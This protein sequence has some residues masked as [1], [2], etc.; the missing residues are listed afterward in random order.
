MFDANIFTAQ[1]GTHFRQD[2]AAAGRSAAHSAALRLYAGTRLHSR[3]AALFGRSQRLPDLAS[4]TR[5]S[6]L[7]GQH[8]AG[9]QTVRIDQI[10]GSE[11]R[12]QDFDAEF[13]PL[14]EHT[15]QR[16]LS[17]A[18][19]WFQGLTLPPVE[20]IQVGDSYFVRDGHHRVSVARAAGQQQIE[21]EVLV[22]QVA[23]NPAPA[24]LF[25]CPALAPT[26]A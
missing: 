26:T 12:S 11:G 23:E 20:L 18:S 7:K 1:Q 14:S 3:L 6:T 8:A 24:P 9:L 10:R 17:V 4:L 25:N 19:A 15:K 16:W 5:H 13:R 2:K 22:W 21:A